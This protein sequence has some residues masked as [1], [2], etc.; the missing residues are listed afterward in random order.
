MGKIA[1]IPKTGD[2]ELIIGTG[3]HCDIALS[4]PAYLPFISETHAMLRR[5]GKTYS[6]KDTNSRQGTFVNGH[7][8]GGSWVRIALHDDISLGQCPFKVAG[9][10]LRDQRVTLE[11]CNLN[12]SID[13]HDKGFLGAKHR[14]ILTSEVSFRAEPG[15]LVGI[16]GPSGA[17]KTVLLN[18]LNGA[19]T[20]G[21]DAKGTLGAVVVNGRFSVHEDQE[22]LR[23]FIGYVP[24]DD[25]LVPELTVRQSLAYSLELK[26]ADTGIEPKFKAA[27]IESTAQ[28]L[29][30]LGDKTGQYLDTLIGSADTRRGL[31]GGERKKANIAHELIKNP[32]LLFLDEPTSGLSSVDSDNIISLL[33]G[34]CQTDKTTILM[35]I[36][37]PSEGSFNLLDKVLILNYGG[38]VGF[39]GTPADAVS[40]FQGKAGVRIGNRN[41]AEFILEALDRWSHAE[42]PKNAY[43]NTIHARKYAPQTDHARSAGEGH[44]AR[45]FTLTGAMRQFATLF[46][47]N[48]SVTKADTGNLWFQVLQPVLIAALLLAS[49]A[50]FRADYHQE[51]HDDRVAYYLVK[52][53]P[54]QGLVFNSQK[55][56]EA[57][58]WA[59]HVDNGRRLSVGAANR[60][61]AVYFLML[62]SA[63]WI[64]IINTC[65]E[66][67][68][69][70]AV[71]GREGRSYLRIS[72]YLCAKFIYFSVMSTLQVGVIVMAVKFALLPA[73]P[74]WFMWGLMALTAASAA[75][76]GLTLSS[77]VNSQRTALTAVPM[78]MIPQLLFGGLVRP[79]RYLDSE[80]LAALDGLHHVML[81]KWAFLAALLGGDRQGIQ[82]LEKVVDL[83][84]F[85]AARRLSYKVLSLVDLFFGKGL[86]NG[87]DG[88]SIAL[89][90]IAVQTLVL[91]AVAYVL[92]R[93]KYVR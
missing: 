84:H 85:D 28:K 12:Y 63:I 65:R 76:I 93:R 62:V 72:S 74:L 15:E 32:L 45:S 19:L 25:M 70:K 11:A 39:Y 55:R 29:G 5:R 27:R 17:G 1:T 8:I 34:L 77:A 56:S 18:L 22:L 10:L 23:D 42:T 58:A 87:P 86:G 64:G 20:P 3:A 46:R 91:L 43:E 81:Q 16:M 47:R 52:D 82:V 31:S 61:G 6:I 30:F 26:Y 13:T 37:Q 36:H 60:L 35:T 49:F 38:T 57:S 89:A 51:D 68:G 75:A 69:E 33:K 9:L 44:A 7:R 71:L 83:A 88:M 54:S 21:K 67:V 48:L 79:I 90:G 24:Q 14:R 2:C 92:L 50:G 66:I 78:V 53:S 80:G 73:M 4:E 41:P 40:Y 59:E